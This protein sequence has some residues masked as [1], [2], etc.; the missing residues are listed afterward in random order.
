MAIM[1]KSLQKKLVGAAVLIALAVIFLP[2]LLDGERTTEPLS[3]NIE[4]PPKPVYQ[5]PN[6]LET[7]VPV[8]SPVIVE[9][10]TAKAPPRH[11]VPPPVAS[12]APARATETPKTVEKPRQ[13]VAKVEPAPVRQPASKPKTAKPAA[14]DSTKKPGAA[15]HSGAGFVVQVGSFSKDV[16]AKQL[17]SKLEREGFPAFV[18]A[19]KLGSKSIYRV[20]VGPRPTRDAA[21]LLRIRLID[22]VKLEGI[23]VSHR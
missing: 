10:G 16:N 19:I 15:S 20:K 23:I 7:R 22:D 12:A 4:I 21:D 17:Q 8:P 11:R 13:Q 3:M 9:S 2:M 18:E 14:P 1:D 5:V 6:R